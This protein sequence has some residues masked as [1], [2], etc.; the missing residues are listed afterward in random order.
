MLYQYE[1]EYYFDSSKFEKHFNFV[2]TSYE[3]G[4]K[5]MIKSL[6]KVVE[7]KNQLNISDISINKDLKYN[8]YI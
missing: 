8:F 3:N 7:N 5:E 6:R 1:I 4:I 2:P